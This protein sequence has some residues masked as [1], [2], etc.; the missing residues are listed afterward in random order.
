M[1]AQQGAGQPGPDAQQGGQEQQASGD[2]KKDEKEVED[3]SYEVV[4]D[5][6]DKK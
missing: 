4:D 3:A 1:Y 2:A 5:E 6:D